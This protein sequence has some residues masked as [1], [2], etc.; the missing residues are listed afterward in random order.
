MLTFIENLLGKRALRALSGLAFC[1]IMLTGCAGGVTNA[2]SYSS[3][4]QM[5]PESVY[6]Y[7]F[8][9]KP[10]Q[11]KLDNGGALK[12]MKSL[13]DDTSATKQQADDAAQVREQVADEIVQQLQS[14]GLHAIRAD[15]P[16]PADRNVLIV[17]G[18]FET[19]D[20]GNRRRRT[21]IGLGAGKSEVGTSVQVLYQAAGQ[22]PKLVQRFDANADSGKAPGVAE[23]AGG[24]AAAG[25]LATSA[26]A[27]GGL[28]GVSEMKHAGMSAEAKRLADS[29]AKQ[30]AQIG[31]G[32]GWM[33]AERTQ[34]S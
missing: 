10:D 22:A 12:K 27:G 33:P 7:A 3:A 25:H 19:I 28:H 29:I 20:A 31:V 26:V 30:V 23:T 8:E 21:L 5:R 9:S 6:V 15:S 24:G 11:V 16:A 14:M 13:F 4:P 34:R 1:A 2:S 32:E 18:S 17:Q